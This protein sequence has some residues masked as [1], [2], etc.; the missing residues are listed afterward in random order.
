MVIIMVSIFVLPVMQTVSAAGVVLN[1][2]PSSDLNSAFA[3]NIVLNY[4]TGIVYVNSDTVTVS[5]DSGY[6]STNLSNADISLSNNDADFTS[7]S[8]ILA[9]PS[10]TCTISATDDIDIGS[11]FTLTIGNVDKMITPSAAG[12][13]AWVMSSSKNEIGIVLQYIAEDNQ[14]NVNANIMPSISFNIRNLDDTNDL[15]GNI[16]DL[17]T[18]TTSTLPNNDLIDD[19]NGECG[20]GLAIGTNAQ[21]GFQVQ[22]ESDGKLDNPQ[23]TIVDVLNGSAWVSGTEAYGFTHIDPASTGRDP[24]TGL[25]DV[26]VTIDGIFATDTSAV[27]EAVT[28]FISYENGIQ[29]T[30]GGN[31]LD[32]TKVMHGMTVGSGTPAGDYD[33]VLRYT[34]TANF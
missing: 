15:D 31:A 27:P 8:C 26:P 7:S 34:V 13:Y 10:V 5:W 20:Y 30:S 4:T 11:V 12:S 17:G 25:Y 18:V 28:N 19:G 33:Q 14:I 32:I 24:F 9:S 6:D 22:L 23:S 3:N 16:C 2:T 21:S 1:I 29:Y